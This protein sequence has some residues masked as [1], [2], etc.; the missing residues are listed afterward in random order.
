[1]NGREYS[2]RIRDTNDTENTQ[3]KHNVI[4][5]SEIECTLDEN[6][7]LRPLGIKCLNTVRGDRV[8]VSQFLIFRPANLSL[9][10]HT[11]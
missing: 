6:P 1:M 11:L 2:A 4:I 9:S 3:L 10:I 7:V 8:I 5:I